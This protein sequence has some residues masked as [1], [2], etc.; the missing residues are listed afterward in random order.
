MN[1]TVGNKTILERIRDQ[2]Y[3]IRMLTM[4]CC[5]DISPDA[6]PAMIGQRAELMNLIASEE[7]LLSKRKRD[8]P[9]DPASDLLRAEIKSIITTIVTLD[10]QVEAVIKSHMQRIQSDLS[11]LYKTSRA[12][13]AYT[14]HSR[15]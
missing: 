9:E 4:H 5:S 12:A 7:R 3:D 6:L 14:I 13:S 1:A 10:K 15:V 11:V 8:E 2:Y